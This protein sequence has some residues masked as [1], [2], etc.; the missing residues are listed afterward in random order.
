MGSAIFRFQKDD[1][2]YLT[3]VQCVDIFPTL[4]S[5]SQSPELTTYSY[6]AHYKHIFIFKSLALNWHKGVI[7]V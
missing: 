5:C 2:D 6:R 1:M 3:L 7:V 4:L